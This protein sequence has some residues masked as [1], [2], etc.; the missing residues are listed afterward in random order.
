LQIFPSGSNV[1]TGLN[2]K[3]INFSVNNIKQNTDMVSHTNK[4]I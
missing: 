4:A 1:F 2:T 3:I